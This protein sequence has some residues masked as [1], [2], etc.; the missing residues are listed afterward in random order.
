MDETAESEGATSQSVG[1]SPTTRDS[2]DSV[3]RDG[4]DRTAVGFALLFSVP[5]WIGITVMMLK[6]TGG[7]PLGLVLAPGLAIGGGVFAF[8][9]LATRGGYDTV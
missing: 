3:G 8:I 5:V 1:A 6:V 4:I 2:D 9:V 7:R